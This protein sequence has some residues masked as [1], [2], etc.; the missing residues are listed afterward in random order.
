MRFFNPLLFLCLA[1]L[2]FTS[3]GV[4][5]VDI[6]VNI[7]SDNTDNS[8]ACDPTI[9][10]AV[11]ECNLR[12][13]IYYCNDYTSVGVNC[14][15]S[16]LPNMSITIDSPTIDIAHRGVV[17]S[18]TNLTISGRDTMVAA[19]PGN[20]V[21]F[22]DVGSSDF[23]TFIMENIQLSDFNFQAGVGGCLQVGNIKSLQLENVTFVNNSAI[24]GGAV[25]VN[26]VEQT[27]FKNCVFK[28]NSANEDGGGLE[29]LNDLIS[30]ATTEIDN[31]LF[32]GN[33]A[34]FC[35]DEVVD[36]Y[37]TCPSSGAAIH[38]AE[39]TTNILIA[40]STFTFNVANLHGGAVGIGLN[41]DHVTILNCQFLHNKADSR[42]GAVYSEGFGY[43]LLIKESLFVN[44]YAHNGGATYAVNVDMPITVKSEFINNIA[45]FDG[46]AQ[47]LNGVDGAVTADNQYIGNSA[48]RGGAIVHNSEILVSNIVSCNFEGNT[49]VQ[50]GGAFASLSVNVFTTFVNL[51][52]VR[53]RCTAFSGGAVAF[54][55]Y[56]YSVDIFSSKFLYNEADEGNCHAKFQIILCN[57]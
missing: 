27:K 42:G 52:F 43:Y 44:N 57:F 34:G 7:G 50:Y 53:N 48:E 30:S 40:N 5:V 28:N 22:L 23:L 2:A 11:R 33:V 15:V 25:F 54:L 38:I 24:S 10:L 12:S 51:T 47:Y 46:G 14:V 56:H 1:A 20:N 29:V 49:A 13:A 3:N 6:L 18:G 31:C 4:N 39:F 16:F 17:Y 36:G 35:D 8:T 19:A 9:E 55:D 21:P 26:N 32:T 41:V 45:F 37:I